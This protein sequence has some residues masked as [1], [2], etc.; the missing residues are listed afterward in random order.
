MDRELI[1]LFRAK[2]RRLEREIG[3]RLKSDAS[4]CGISVAQC[5]VLQEIAAQGEIAIIELADRLGLDPSTL[6]RTIDHMVKGEMVNRLVDPGDR[7]YVALTLT[8]KGNEIFHTIETMYYEYFTKIFSCI[9]EEKHA[10]V[11]ESFCLFADALQKSK[12]QCDCYCDQ[13]GQEE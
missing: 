10:Q 11:V 6:S 13:N 8:E 1:G 7:R 2:L 3:W 12:A 9:P 4:C 5:H